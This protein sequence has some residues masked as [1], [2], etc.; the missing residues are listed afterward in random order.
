[1]LSTSCDSAYGRLV[2][3]AVKTDVV[4]AV[5]G[6]KL[7]DAW[8]WCAGRDHWEFHYGDFFWHGSAD[9]AFDARAKGWS[10]YLEKLGID[11]YVRD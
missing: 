11:G 3:A 4:S 6:V 1:M 7:R 8:V 5:A 2:Y 9:G 10:A